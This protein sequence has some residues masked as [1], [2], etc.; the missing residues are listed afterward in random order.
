[1][2]L[3]GDVEQTQTLLKKPPT[4]AWWMGSILDW[5]LGAGGALSWEL[6]L[7]ISGRCLKNESEFECECE[8][9]CGAEL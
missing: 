3:S 4:L 6:E 8:C 2:D 7:G 1:M 9:E 5:E